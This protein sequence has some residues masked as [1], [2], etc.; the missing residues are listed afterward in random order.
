MKGFFLLKKERMK[1]RKVVI[2][3]ANIDSHFLVISL[4]RYCITFQLSRNMQLG[5][6]GMDHFCPT[7][8]LSEISA[9]E[10]FVREQKLIQTS[11]VSKSP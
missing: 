8:P 10:C 6:A 5:L 9:K 7:C 11:Q 1:E 4:P 2:R 3:N